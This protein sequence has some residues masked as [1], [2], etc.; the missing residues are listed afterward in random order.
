MLLRKK[1]SVCS[2][3]QIDIGIKFVLCK[4]LYQNIVTLIL[5]CVYILP[6]C[7]GKREVA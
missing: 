3:D 7:A 2:Y 6:L 5:N 4:V 1:C